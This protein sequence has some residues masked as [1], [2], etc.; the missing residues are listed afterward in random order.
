[1]FKDLKAQ[2]QENF[3]NFGQLYV[4]GINPDELWDCYLNGFEDELEKLRDAL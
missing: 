3:K 4:V 1:M 2:V